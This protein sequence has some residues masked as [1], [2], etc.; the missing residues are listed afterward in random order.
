MKTL[1]LDCGMGA[2]G[3]MLTAALLE[4]FPDPQKMVDK[5]NSFG[6]PD[7]EFV[8]EK[9]VK[10]GIT[11]THMTVRYK[12]VGEDEEPHGHEH[13]HTHEEQ[14]H[15]HTHGEQ[16]HHH[17]HEEGHT[18]PHTHH[19]LKD[20]EHVIK[21]HLDVPESVREDILKVFGSIAEAESHVHGVPVTDIHFHEVGTMDAV[22][23][24]AAVCLL[25]NELGPDE[26]V[27]SP[28]HVGSGQ[29]KCAHGILPVPAPATAYILKDVPIYGGEV[30]GELCTPTGAALLKHFVNRFASMPVMR[31]SAIGYGMGKKDFERA[32][33]V[34]AC[35]GESGT[36]TDTV[37]ELSCNVDDMTA[38]SIAFATEK[39]LEAGARDVYTVPVGMK[40]GRPGTLIRLLCSKGDED[41]MAELMFR[42]TTT[43]G[44][45]KAELQRYVLDRRIETENT[46]YGPVRKKISEGFGVKR[47]KYEYEDLS[48]IAREQGKSLEEIKNTLDER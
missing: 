16:E 29:V 36:G 18:H 46:V 35:L 44:I 4:L 17:T 34:R 20:I 47:E 45:R 22:A 30:R 33:C 12:G 37:I 8:A 28:V 43:L 39:L 32:N 7:V 13:H 26:I 21:E 11:G 9:S 48:K 14:E 40:K 24:V 3:D 6:I 27:A 1:Y 10:C 41:R 2:A 5:L 23:D 42:H 19:G 25:L 15:H 38:E 31:V